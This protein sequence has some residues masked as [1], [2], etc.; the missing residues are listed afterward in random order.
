MLLIGMVPALIFFAWFQFMRPAQIEEIDDLDRQVLNLQQRNQ[1]TRQLIAR[2]GGQGIQAQVEMVQQHIRLLEG[3][4]PDA[5]EVA[6]LIHQVTELTNETGVNFVGLVP[7]SL[8]TEEPGYYTKQIYD[9]RVSGG[10]HQIGQLLARIGS[11]ERII[12]PTEVELTRSR[13]EA[14][15]GAVVVDAQFKIQTFVLPPPQPVP[16]PQGGTGEAS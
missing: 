5:E 14:P 15:Q 7:A 3:L 9:M 6:G 12:T 16:E 1:A 11:M 2:L 4:I 13:Q 8:P 10:Y